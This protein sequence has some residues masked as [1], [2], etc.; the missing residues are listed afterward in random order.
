VQA[1]ESLEK[2]QKLSNGDGRLYAVLS[3]MLYTM[4]QG[5]A[6]KD[7]AFDKGAWKIIRGPLKALPVDPEVIE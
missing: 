4:H 1:E 5:R 2:Y 6:K 7:P 3:F